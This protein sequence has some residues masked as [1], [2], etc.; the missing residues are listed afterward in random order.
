MNLYLLR[1]IILESDAAYAG[2]FKK[3][4]EI[5]YGKYKNKKGKIKDIYLDDNDRPTIDIEPFPKGKKKTVS[6]GLYKIWSPKEP[7]VIDDVKESFLD[8]R[9]FIRE[10][11]SGSDPNE[12]YDKDLVDDPAFNKDSVYVPNDVKQKIKGWVKD[13]KLSR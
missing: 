5:L 7:F 12:S 9:K 4:D 6:T 3:G 10:E 1:Q 11:L 2:M 13:M 8:L